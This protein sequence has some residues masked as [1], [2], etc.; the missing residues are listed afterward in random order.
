MPF[1]YQTVGFLAHEK[2]KIVQ[3]ADVYIV[4]INIT[5]NRFEFIGASTQIPGVSYI[6]FPGVSKNNIGF[7]LEIPWSDIKSIMKTKARAMHVIRIDTF[8]TFYTILPLDPQQG[9]RKVISSSKRNAIDLMATINK[10]KAQLE[11]SS[12]NFCTECGEPI[13]P[14]SDFCGNCGQKIT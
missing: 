12:S 11:S 1:L 7:R 3:R 6:N 5:P 2:M 9:F 4:N 8:D 10:A 13:K 14:G